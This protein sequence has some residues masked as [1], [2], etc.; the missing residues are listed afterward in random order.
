MSLDCEEVFS[1]QLRAILRAAAKAQPGQ[2]S[3]LFPMISNIEELRKIK[4]LL[5]K[6]H[7]DLIRGGYPTPENIR[8]GIMVEIPSVALLAEKFAREVDFFSIGSNDLV[9]YTLAVDRTNSKVSHLYQPA[10]PAV[11][12]LISQVVAVARQ[13]NVGVSLCGEMAGDTRYT[14]LLL[15]LG[16]RE[17]SMN[18]VLIPSVKQILRSVSLEEI[19]KLIA[20]VLNL[21]TAEEI[22]QALNKI[23]HKLGIQ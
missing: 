16:L 6:M 22:E 12:K 1:T 14:T 18:A 11:I 21:D 4:A 8:I 9:Q 20:P 17:L 2:V 7:E 15:G 19:Q 10:N 13:H 3:I 23:N 5:N